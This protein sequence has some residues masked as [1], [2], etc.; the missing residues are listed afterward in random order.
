MTN[1]F[2]MLSNRQKF[3]I[4][5]CL[6]ICVKSSIEPLTSPMVLHMYFVSIER[7]SLG[8]TVRLLHCDLGVVG[9]KHGD[10]L[11]ARRNKSTD[12]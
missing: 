6:L 7:E 11:F 1:F 2:H 9:L 10:N 8:S 4:Q 5:I 3:G 12:I